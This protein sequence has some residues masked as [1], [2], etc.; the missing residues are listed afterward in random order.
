KTQ[1]GKL[2]PT[3]KVAKAIIATLPKQQQLTGYHIESLAIEAIKNYEGQRTYKSMV[4]HF[5]E[6]ASEL[7]KAPV[8]D[9]TGQSVYV[10]QHLG[11]ANSVERRLASQ[12]LQR[13][14][15]KLKNADASKSVE[16]WS[17]LLAGEKPGD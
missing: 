17:E 12:A 9:R 15:R 13:V 3:I 16:V 8:V 2:V 11:A 4:T 10:D 6:R 7:V 5:F 14:H 1:D